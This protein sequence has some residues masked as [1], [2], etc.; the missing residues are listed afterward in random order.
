[1]LYNEESEMC[2]PENDDICKHPEKL[3]G[4]P[5]ECTPQQILECHGKTEGHPC[6]EESNQNNEGEVII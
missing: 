6:P 2:Q 4:K 1:M 3:K 5:G